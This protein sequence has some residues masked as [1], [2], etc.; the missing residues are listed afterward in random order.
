M[1]GMDGSQTPVWQSLTLGDLRDR[2]LSSRANEGGG[3]KDRPAALDFLL[4]D[5]QGER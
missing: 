5:G 2:K 3:S 4:P 1:S